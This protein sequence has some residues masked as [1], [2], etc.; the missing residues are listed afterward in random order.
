MASP[1]TRR[2]LQEI[3]PKNENSVSLTYYFFQHPF[4]QVELDLNIIM[5]QSIHIFI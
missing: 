3:R 4:Q 5:H 2:V 1:R